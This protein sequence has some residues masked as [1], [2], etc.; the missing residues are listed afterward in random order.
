VVLAVEWSG[1]RSDRQLGLG[2][3]RKAN[4]MCARVRRA[5]EKSEEGGREGVNCRGVEE[6]ER[7][8][9]VGRLSMQRWE[10]S[11]I[12]GELAQARSQQPDA[13]SRPA[14]A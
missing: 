1:Q 10:L 2:Q 3:S 7:A 9:R 11:A 6:G 12:Y 4:W 13:D 5:K 8:R 14:A